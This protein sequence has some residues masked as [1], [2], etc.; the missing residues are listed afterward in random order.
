[1]ADFTAKRGTRFGV[2]LAS[3]YVPVGDLLTLAEQAEGLGYDSVWVTEGRMA[4]DAV[5]AAAAVA[6]RT[7]KVRIGTSVLNP[8]SRSPGLLAVSAASL[9]QLSQGRFVL[10]I[11]PGDAAVLGRQGIPFHKPLTRLRE[12]VHVV[13]EL[14]AGRT[15]SYDGAVI[16][17]RDLAIDVRPYGAQIPVYIGATGPRALEQATQIGDGILLNVC[18]PRHGVEQILDGAHRGRNVRVMGNIVVGMHKQADV[19]IR[20]TK[21]LIV[22]Y[23]TRFPATAKASGLTESLLADIAAAKTESM[24]AA[25]DLLPDECVHQLAAVGDPEDCRRWI[26]DYTAGMDEALL[27]P[28]FGDPHLI[29]DELAALL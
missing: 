19:A 1:M 11:G 9:D 18:V 23:L 2:K 14:L 25:C 13:R 15:V 27:M 10:G 16:T 17:V 29:I 5:S 3:H 6:A 21:P 8:F 22:T 26:A 24:E 7:S 12:C 4:P 20:G 28:S